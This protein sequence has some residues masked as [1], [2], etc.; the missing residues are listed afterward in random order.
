M[1]AFD[2]VKLYENFDEVAADLIVEH[3]RKGYT[4]HAGSMM[5]RLYYRDHLI[6]TIVETLGPVTAVPMF[7]GQLHYILS[8]FERWCDAC[9]IRWRDYTRIIPRE[10]EKVLIEMNAHGVPLN[11]KIFYIIIYY[12][13]MI[14][15][16]DDA[17][18]LFQNMEQRGFIT[19]NSRTYALMAR[20]FYKVRR[21]HERDEMVMKVGNM[22][23]PLR[24]EDSHCFVKILCKAGMSEHA[25]RVFE[26]MNWDGFF[27]KANTYNMLIENLSSF[28]HFFSFSNKINAECLLLSQKNNLSWWDKGDALNTVFAIAK[29]GRLPMKEMSVYLSDGTVLKG[30]RMMHG[31]SIGKFVPHVGRYRNKKE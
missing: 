2:A 14:R 25:V 8:F 6:K 1:A 4:G 21:I 20:A 24:S 18:F 12:L 27:L 13:A 3:W 17:S 29:K 16:T 9:E 31:P 7:N 23:P 5:R 10:I 11:V 15:R 19:P 22:L 28:G 30:S 26:M